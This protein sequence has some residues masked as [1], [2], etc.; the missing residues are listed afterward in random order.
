MAAMKSR[1][2]GLDDVIESCRQHILEHAAMK[3]RPEGLDD[4]SLNSV[5]LTWE[6]TGRCER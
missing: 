5:A 1:P 3:S 2:E 4:R 6:N